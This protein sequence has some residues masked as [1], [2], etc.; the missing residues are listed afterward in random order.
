MNLRS[1]RQENM[2]MSKRLTWDKFAVKMY[3]LTNQ[4]A[5][6]RQRPKWCAG[7]RWERGMSNAHTIKCE[8]QGSPQ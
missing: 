2:R 1:D 6:L 8:S 5:V 7:M 3:D 4:H